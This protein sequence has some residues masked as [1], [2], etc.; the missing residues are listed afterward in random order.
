MLDSKGFDNWILQ[1]DGSVKRSDEAGEYPFAG[2]GKILGTIRDR[3]LAAPGR[4]VLDLGFG[5]AAL[6]AQLYEAGCR[7]YGQD[8]S[9]GMRA[10]AQ[11]KMP[12]AKLYPGD[13][14]EALAEELNGRQYDAIVATYALHHLTD[15][16]KIALLK[17]LLPMLK[18][19]GCLYIGDISFPTRAAMEACRAA[20]AGSWDDDEI[21]CVHEELVK[22]FPTMTFEAFSQCG[23][24]MMIK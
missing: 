16:K 9:E 18:E 21:Y 14:S 8:F 1:Y 12:E 13:F 15:E 2:Y 20:N 4:D 10:L 6:T 11:E 7:I 22:E 5:T 3:I 19:G 17:R 23:G 24:L